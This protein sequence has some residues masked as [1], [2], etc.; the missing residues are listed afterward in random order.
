MAKKQNRARIGGSATPGAKSTQSKEVSS[1][2]N[3][4]QQE[5]ESY[6]R[7]MRRRME[8][9]GAGPYSAENRKVKTPLERRKEKMDRIKQKRAEQVASVRKTLPGGRIKTDVSRATR[10]VLVIGG[11]IVLL[12]AVFAVLRLANVIG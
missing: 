5:I 8:Q 4:Q 10:M 9:I 12:I 11:A 2:N 1:T 7:T 3:P 6:N